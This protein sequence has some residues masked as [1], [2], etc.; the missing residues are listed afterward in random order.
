[1]DITSQRRKAAGA[2]FRG[3]RYLR[4]LDNSALLDSLRSSQFL[5]SFVSLEVLFCEPARQRRNGQF[6]LTQMAVVAELEAGLM[7]ERTKAALAAA[8]QRGGR[9]G[10]NGVEIPAHALLSF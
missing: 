9:L 5:C 10:H 3:G 1:M 4:S 8:K 2:L 7:G 6:I